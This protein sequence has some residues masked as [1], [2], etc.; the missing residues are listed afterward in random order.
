M[1]AAWGWPI[2]A[3]VVLTGFRSQRVRAWV[4]LLLAGSCLV[5]GTSHALGASREDTREGV[6]VALAEGG[7]DALYT[8][9]LFHPPWYAHKTPFDVYAPEVASVEYARVPRDAGRVVVVTRRNTYVLLRDYFRMIEE[10]RE[11][12]KTIQVDERTFVHV[13]DPK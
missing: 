2:A 7:E 11:L 5:M 4:A 13:F 1:V 9:V 12:V 6:R 8:G 3:G 10:G